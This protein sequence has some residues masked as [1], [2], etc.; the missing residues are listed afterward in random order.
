MSQR[1]SL[2]KISVIKSDVRGRHLVSV[3]SCRSLIDI[4]EAEVEAVFRSIRLQEG[5]TPILPRRAF[6]R[7]DVTQT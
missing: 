6:L 3:S 1:V 7:L 2:A 5:T 4:T